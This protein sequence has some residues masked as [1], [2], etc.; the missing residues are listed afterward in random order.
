MAVKRN[1]WD[2]VARECLTEVMSPFEDAESSP[3]SAALADLAGPT[4]VVGDLGCGSGP[5]LP[6]LLRC[7]GRVIAI[8]SSREMLRLAA[9]RV[10]GLP[11]RGTSLEFRRAALASLGRKGPELDVAVALNSIVSSDAVARGAS[12]RG[13]ARG[14]QPG[15]VLL[16]V[17]PSL[18]SVR[19]SYRFCDAYA[20]RDGVKG[21]AARRARLRLERRFDFRRGL[22]DA[23]VM[24]QKY[25]DRVELEE[26]LLRAGF[27]VTGATWGRVVYPLRIAFDGVAEL[28][29]SRPR[30]WHWFVRCGNVDLA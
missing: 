21:A 2:R 4:R 29:R 10:S 27:A 17:F 26:E 18:E 16:A 19:E 11:L 3:L 30:V 8:D 28:G 5:L 20:R 12:L 14:L 24:R 23:R 15:G 6:T 13:V 25:F 7:F 22:F 9:A 1:P